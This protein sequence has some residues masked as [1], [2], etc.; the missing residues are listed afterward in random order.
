MSERLEEMPQY[1]LD[2]DEFVKIIEETIGYN[3]LDDLLNSDYFGPHI[4]RNGDFVWFRNDDEYYVIHLPSGMMVNWY[5]HLGR[6]NTCSQPT[7]T[8]EDYFEFFTKL[9]DECIKHGWIDKKI[10]DKKG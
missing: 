7:R 9:R 5:K 2:R 6:T 3:V 1:H 10:Y 8:R 4:D